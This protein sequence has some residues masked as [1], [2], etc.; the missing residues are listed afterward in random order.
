MPGAR[1]R[2]SPGTTGGCSGSRGIPPTRAMI[3]REVIA[4]AAAQRPARHVPGV[5]ER[6]TSTAAPVS[7]S[8]ASTASTCSARSRAARGRCGRLA[9]TLGVE[10]AALHRV[11]RPRSC[12]SCTTEL[13]HRLGSPLVPDEV[14][15][16]CP[17][18]ARGAA[19][20]RPA[21]ARRL[22]SGEPAADGR[23]LRRDRLDERHERRS[24]CRCRPD[25]PADRRGQAGRRH[26]VVVRVIAPVA[27]R[28]LSR[29]YLRA[30]AREAPLDRGLVD[31]WLPVW[32]A[33]RLAEDIEPERE[34]LLER[35]R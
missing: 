28:A 29:G 34:F 16:A 4:L 5:H 21:S 35:A 22:P 12:R 23:R 18:A 2:S 17:R 30:Y 1:R 8:T 26:S 11:R 13:R 25:D 15:T 20:R 19:R 10:H 31:R 9:T 3:E 32:A 24:G 6:V 7:S 27:R 33:A 14:R